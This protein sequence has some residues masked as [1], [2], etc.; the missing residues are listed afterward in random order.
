M[1]RLLVLPVRHRAPARR[2]LPALL[3][4]SLALPAVAQPRQDGTAFFLKLYATM[5]VQAGGDAGVVED[6][7]GKSGIS[8]L[9]ADEA[10]PFLQGRSGRV[11]PVL[12]DSGA[13]RVVLDD[14]GNCSILAQRAEPATLDDAFEDF[15]RD[16]PLQAP[17]RMAKTADEQRRRNGIATRYQRFEYGIPGKPGAFVFTLTTSRDV[18]SAVQAL[19][20]FQRT[21]DA[22][23]MP[24]LR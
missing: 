6:A 16:A 13:Y 23:P 3:A 5:C 21:G 12:A 14:E 7:M 15:L 10:A 22:V 24:P 1:T 4:A 2:A 17:F 9:P 20:T 19:A 8:A 11:W 18:R